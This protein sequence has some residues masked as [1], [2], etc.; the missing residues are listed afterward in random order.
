M[1]KM[2]VTKLSQILE[3]HFPHSSDQFIWDV[4]LIDGDGNPTGQTIR[5]WDNF[6][7]RKFFQKYF[8]WSFPW[9]ET[10]EYVNRPELAFDIAVEDFKKNY[11]DSV[12]RIISAFMMQYNPIH[13]YDK[14]VKEITNVKTEDKNAII[15]T[16]HTDSEGK[17]VT[18]ADSTMNGDADHY[19]DTYDN[20]TNKHDSRST[21]NSTTTNN[22]TTDTT[23][24]LDSNGN[25]DERKNGTSNTDRDYTETGN[26][27]VTTSQQMLQAEWDLRMKANWEDYLLDVFANENFILVP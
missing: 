2:K 13:N 27:G 9:F 10:A 15:Q 25:T 14:V 19:V 23:N 17:A 12:Q 26:I 11:K 4:D 7:W 6:T 24:S 20:F 16:Y 21:Q 1:A 18:A 5:V 8:D 22:N 3:E